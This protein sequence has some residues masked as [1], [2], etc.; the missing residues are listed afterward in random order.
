M[1]DVELLSQAGRC[2]SIKGVCWSTFSFDITLLLYLL[3]L[4][5]LCVLHS[6]WQLSKLVE[7]PLLQAVT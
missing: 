7:P 6:I 4:A 1:F 2:L 3:P 5:R